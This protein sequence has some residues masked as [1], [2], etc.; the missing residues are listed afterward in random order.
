[1]LVL[2]PQII[3]YFKSLKIGECTAKTVLKFG[4]RGPKIMTVDRSHPEYRKL[5]FVCAGVIQ[6]K[7]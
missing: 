3:F 4:F 2:D 6:L 5:F 7:F 1:M